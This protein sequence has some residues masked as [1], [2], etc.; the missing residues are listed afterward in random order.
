[1]PETLPQVRSWRGWTRGEGLVVVA[2]ILLIADLVLLPWH[3]Y[4]LNVNTGD[5]PIEL[6]TFALDR[7]GVESPDAQLGIGAL[8]LAGV[9]V[10]QLLAAKATSAVPKWAFLHLIVGPAAF[11]LLAAKLLSDDQFLGAGAWLGQLLGAALALGGYFFSQ[12]AAILADGARGS[13]RAG[14]GS[15]P[16]T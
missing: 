11:G 4:A 16:P 1:M 15:V 2:G 9:M 7:T 8:V 3:H 5:L 6:P 13:A 10:V 12:E 14:T